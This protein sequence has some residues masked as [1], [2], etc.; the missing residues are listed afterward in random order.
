MGGASAV[1]T[2]SSSHMVS[3]QTPAASLRGVT[4]GYQSSGE[5]NASSMKGVYMP[6]S[7]PYDLSSS[8]RSQTPPMVGDGGEQI[9]SHPLIGGS[10]NT[11][12]DK[13]VLGL[14]FLDGMV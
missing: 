12:D 10:M 1:M 9:E 8:T 7:S 2:P 11:V 3:Q 5:Y 13:Q 4:S 14:S 6:N